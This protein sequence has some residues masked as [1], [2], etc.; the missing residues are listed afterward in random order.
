MKRTPIRREENG[1]GPST[2]SGERLHRLHI[3][4]VDIW[5]FLAVYLY[6][7]KMLVHDGGSI[8]V[9]EGFALHDMAP[10]AGRIANA[11]QNRFIFPFCLFQ[12]FLAPGIPIYRVVCVL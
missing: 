11:E 3:D 5:T 6:R 4:I 8:L 7:D 9:L 10:V 12:G 2:L 1:H